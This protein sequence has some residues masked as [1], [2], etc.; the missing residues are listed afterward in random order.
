MRHFNSQNN[1]PL[2]ITFKGLLNFVLPNLYTPSQAGRFDFGIT[3]Y[4]KTNEICFFSCCKLF[5]PLV[6]E[7]EVKRI[8]RFCGISVVFS[9]IPVLSCFLLLYKSNTDGMCYKN[10]KNAEVVL[11]FIKT[12]CY[13]WYDVGSRSQISQHCCLYHADDMKS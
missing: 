5:S 10:G 4:N 2:F 9:W 8:F 13:H 11:L 7:V 1:T 6:S 12:R 3:W